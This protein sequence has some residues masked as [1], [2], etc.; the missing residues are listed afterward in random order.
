[1]NDTQKINVFNNVSITTYIILYT[2]LFIQQLQVREIF[3]SDILLKA[4]LA[5]AEEDS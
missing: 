2:V 1:M 5:L 3:V 4:P